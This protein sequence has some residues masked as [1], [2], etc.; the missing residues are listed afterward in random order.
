MSRVSEEL[1][2]YRSANVNLSVAKEQLE[3]ELGILQMDSRR[4]ED[5][6]ECMRAEGEKK[7]RA[8]EGQLELLKQQISR[9][10]F[11]LQ[12]SQGNVMS[13]EE[14]KRRLQE[15]KRSLNEELSREHFNAMEQVKNQSHLEIEQER[16]QNR[17]LIDES[18]ALQAQL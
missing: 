7:S 5:G 1:K 14:E 17:L 18:R 10:T 2:E 8:H 13:K 11:E 16:R 12:Q 9:M 15:E 6:L 3:H 4:L